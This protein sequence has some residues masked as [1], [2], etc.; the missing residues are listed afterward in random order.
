MKAKHSLL[1]LSACFFVANVAANEP[2]SAFSQLDKNH[3]GFI[4]QI[5]ASADRMLTQLFQQLDS[6]QDQQLSEQEFS[7]LGSSII[8]LNTQKP[9]RFFY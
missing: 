5:E 7:E 8:E 4:N 9:A 6:N 3:D 1:T 2:S